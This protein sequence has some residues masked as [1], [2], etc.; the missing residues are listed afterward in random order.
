[1][2]HLILMC[3]TRLQIIWSDCYVQEYK[4][5]WGKGAVFLNDGWMDEVKWKWG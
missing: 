4:A 1:M 3:G 5:R 2:K